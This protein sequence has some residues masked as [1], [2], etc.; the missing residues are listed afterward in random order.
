MHEEST[1]EEVLIQRVSYCCLR[2]QQ[3]FNIEEDGRDS[4]KEN[5]IYHV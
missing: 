3:G 5:E 2:H 4:V 1:A